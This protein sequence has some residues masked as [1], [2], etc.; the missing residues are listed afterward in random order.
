MHGIGVASGI[1][2]KDVGIS[3]LPLYHDMGLIGSLFVTMYWNIPAVMMKPEAFIFKPQWWLENMTKYGVTMTVSP[4]FG[5]HYCVSRISDSQLD[6]IDLSTLRLALNGAEPVD[7]ITL[8]KFVD[9][10]KLEHKP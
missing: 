9:K 5:Y 2:E 6:H 8:N 7:R 10:F 4:N 3:W 1:S